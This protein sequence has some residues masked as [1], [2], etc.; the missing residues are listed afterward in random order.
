MQRAAL[1]GLPVMPRR[2]AIATHTEVMGLVASM[3]VTDG[4]VVVYDAT[5]GTVKATCDGH[6]VYWAM[7]KGVPG[8]W[9]VQYSTEYFGDED[10]S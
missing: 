8:H 1:K 10:S 5:A 9:I 6:I 7:R 3:R 2:P 4:W